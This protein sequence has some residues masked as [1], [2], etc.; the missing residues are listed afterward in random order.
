MNR[1]KR[2]SSN[3]LAATSFALLVASFGVSSGCQIIAAVDRSSIETGGSGGSST[4]GMGGAGGMTVCSTKDDCPG[5]D[6]VCRTRICM[7]G[8]C[9]FSNA[10]SGT[11]TDNQIIGDC[12]HEICD[13]MGTVTTEP[14]A[15][16]TLDDMKDCTSDLCNAG[17]PE[18]VPLAMGTV[19]ASN[20]GTVCNDQGSCVECNA[21]VDCA[22]GLCLS[23]QCVPATCADAV[24]NGSETDIDCGGA[25]CTRCAD[26]LVCGIATDCQSGVCTNSLCTASSCVDM[27]DNG[28]ETDVDCGGDTC[29]PCGP[30]LGCAQD[31]D[32]IGGSCSG[33]L[34][35]AT[36]TDNVTNSNETDIDCGGPVC[37]P[38]MTGQTCS[39][40]SDCV[41]GVCTGGQ[42]EAADCMDATK[43]GNETGID[44]GGDC[45]TKCTDGDGCN[46]GTDCTSGVC[47]MMVCQAATCSDMTKNGLETDIDCGGGVCAGCGEGKICIQNVD[48]ASNLCVM[49][50]CI[51][52]VCGDGKLS[53]PEACDDGNLNAGDGCSV[54]CA[55]EMGYGCSGT[56]STCTPICG[57]GMKLGAEACDDNNINNGDCC[58]SA[59]TTESG[60][61]IEPNDTDGTANTWAMVATGN[62]VKAFNN[63]TLDKDVFSIVVPPN[64]KG[65]LT[66][67]VKD[68]PLGATCS[69][70]TDIDSYLTVRNSSGTTIATNDDIIQPTNYCSKVSIN[71][72]DPGTYFVEAKRTTLAPAGIATYDYTLQIDL[73][74]IACGDGV[75]GAG[76]SCDDTNTM[77]GDGC[78]SSCAIEQGWGCSGQPSICVLTCG[79]G[80]VTGNEQCDDGNTMN[81][82]GCSDVC[83]F[84]S[85]AEAEPNNVCAQASGPFLPPF[86]L[87]GAITPIGDQDF[88]AIDVP[89]YADLKIETF[90]PTYGTCAMGNDTVIEL[91]GPNCST[92]LVTDDEDGINSC[93]FIDSTIVADASARHLAPGTYFVRVEDYLN[94]G[95]ISA[96]KLQVSF[97][98]LCGNGVQEGSEQCDGGANCAADCLLLPFCGDGFVANAEQCD[99]GATANGDG[100]SSTCTV[101]ADYRCTGTPSICTMYETNCNDG[102]DNDGDGNTD[103]TDADCTLPIYFPGCQV[104]ET[105]RVYKSFDTPKSIPDN[106]PMGVPSFISVVN[107]IGTIASTALL[108]NATHTW[109]EDIDATLISPANVSFDLTSDNG[110]SSDNYTGTLFQASCPLITSGMPPFTNCYA[111]EESL[112]TLIGTPAQGT[113][114]LNIADDATDDLGALTNW[115]VVLC[116]VP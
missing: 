85:T 97:N 98:A 106:S 100:C 111:P 35:L 46:V 88:I 11:P 1:Q 50:I 104:G 30:G 7:G 15:T 73:A 67:E 87:D 82:D 71:N 69:S 43:N 91:R 2:L 92:V 75:L 3:R 113:W 32:C 41:T 17:S 33:T 44:C 109:V 64:N 116:V 60:C 112:A 59:C 45:M 80:M 47:S 9:G 70:P 10:A 36:C 26:G 5:T 40:G 25:D 52:A 110:G 20:G 14:D 115:A 103:S 37:S 51:G 102:I 8:T 53:A 95:V 48:C 18:N 21:S 23:N 86:L 96:Y 89:N 114:Q 108:L 34:C 24:K 101:E 42:C 94:N 6:T 93:S 12:K 68:G 57:D 29:G 99:D 55:V 38:C 83:L 49:G 4:G 66:A 16:D 27:V 77:N 62:K 76:E 56:P 78:S 39:V 54:M 72:L 28:D 79:N 63:P 65:T 84:E 90:A 13:G 107:N 22:D 74:L 31:N 61:E 105:L 81:G 19:C 58:S